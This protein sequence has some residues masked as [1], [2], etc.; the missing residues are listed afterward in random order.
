[1]SELITFKLRVS[2][3]PFENKNQQMF[4]SFRSL[5]RVPQHKKFSLEPRYYDAEKEELESR[6]K[7]STADAARA[8]KLRREFRI[9]GRFQDARYERSTY[10]RVQHQKN[11][12]TVR[13]LIILN[14]LLI[15]VLYI[16]VK[17]L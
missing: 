9:S 16:F 8:D 2:L 13:F 1:M 14:L 5:S 4:H 10:K 12:A 15:I 6:V 3:K 7:L 17:V 11:M